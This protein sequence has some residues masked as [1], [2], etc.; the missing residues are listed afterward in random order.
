MDSSTYNKLSDSKKTAITI[1]LN[2]DLLHA[3]DTQFY[4]NISHLSGTNKEAVIFAINFGYGDYPI[5]NHGAMFENKPQYKFNAFISDYAFTNKQVQ[6]FNAS[7]LTDPVIGIAR[8]Q[9]S[10]MPGPEL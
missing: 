7:L 4:Y 5:P 3:A 8:T 9:S 10:T 2:E 6:N 1:N